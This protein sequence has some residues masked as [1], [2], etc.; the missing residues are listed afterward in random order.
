M[1]ILSFIAS[2]PPQSQEI[3]LEQMP[4][5]ENYSKHYSDTS[6]RD[7]PRKLIATISFEHSKNF[8]NWCVGVSKSKNAKG[9][10]F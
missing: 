3:V 4:D 10:D 7:E 5:A 2:P 8:F 9:E 1:Y 6:K